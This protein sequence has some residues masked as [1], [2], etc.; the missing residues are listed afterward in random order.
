MFSDF[1][2]PSLENMDLELISTKPL[3]TPISCSTIDGQKRKINKSD[4]YKHALDT[5]ENIGEIC[6]RSSSGD[7]AIP[8]LLGLFGHKNT[9]IT[10]DNGTGKNRRK[11]RIDSSSLE[12]AAK[13]LS[14]LPWK[15]R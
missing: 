13:G 9:P 2:S 8:I 4:L 15:I 3:N 14:W 1:Y 5:H 12:V 11:L 6:V 7:I 10:S